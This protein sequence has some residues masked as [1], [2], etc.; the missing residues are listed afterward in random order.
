MLLAIIKESI[1][2]LIGLCQSD[3][4]KNGFNLHVSYE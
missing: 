3:R 2:K 4:W 1:I